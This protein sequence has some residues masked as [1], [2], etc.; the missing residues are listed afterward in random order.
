MRIDL[1]DRPGH[2]LKS[3]AADCIES[4]KGGE[5]FALDTKG[6]RPVTV[7]ITDEDIIA[8]FYAL[9]E[10]YEHSASRNKKLRLCTEVMAR[11]AVRLIPKP[12]GRDSSVSDLKLSARARNCLKGSDVRTVGDLEHKTEGDLLKNK[13]FGRKSLNEVKAVLASLGLSLR[14]ESPSQILRHEQG[15]DFR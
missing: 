4:W 2:R 15:K 7:E 8:L 5:P 6:L 12:L 3:E 1:G 10:R 9:I 14:H 11:L 13:N